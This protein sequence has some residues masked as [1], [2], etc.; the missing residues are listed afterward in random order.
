MAKNRY[1]AW[2]LEGQSGIEESWPDCEAI[3]R[4]RSA[5]Y[6]GF[7][8]REEAEQWLDAGAAY[9]VK[10]R[11]TPRSPRPS[12]TSLPEDA[13]YFDAGTGRGHGTEARVSDRDGTPLTFKAKA[14][15]GRLTPEGNLLL[16]GRTNNYGELTAC[17]LALQIALDMGLK[18]VMGDSRLVIDY[19]SRGHIRKEAAAD[20][21]LAALVRHV[22]RLRKAFEEAGGSLVHISGDVNPADLGFHR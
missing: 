6:R 11:T 9:E 2:T 18:K 22:A 8:T 20:A 1:Y 16:T 14:R 7:P 5:R 21:E 3:V 19:W 13:L 4:G 17:G 10:P 12:K 15:E